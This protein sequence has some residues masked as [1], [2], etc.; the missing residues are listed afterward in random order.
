MKKKP[1]LFKCTFKNI[2]LFPLMRSLNQGNA[3]IEENTP[4]VF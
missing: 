1:D 3:A 4:H 2:P